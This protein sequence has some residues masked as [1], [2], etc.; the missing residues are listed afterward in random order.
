VNT[1]EVSAKTDIFKIPE[2]LL[3]GTLNNRN[4]F[5]TLSF[6][7]L[8]LLFFWLAA[9]GNAI[10][11][12]SAEDSSFYREAISNV[13][14]IY[15]HSLGEQLGIYNGPRYLQHPTLNQGHAYFNSSS[16]EYG[17]VVYDGILYDSVRLLYDEVKDELVTEDFS[18]TNFVQLIK[19]RTSAFTIREHRFVRIDEGTAHASGISSGFY[20]VL[21]DGKSRVL[22][23]ETKKITE[24]VMFGGAPGKVI[25]TK[26]NYFILHEGRYHRIKN[27]R[28]LLESFSQ[29]KQD[30]NAF[31]RKQDLS[32]KKN[33]DKFLIAVAA[34]YDQL[35]K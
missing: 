1:Q 4:C 2:R 22:K 14:K 12:S 31:I 30:L 18:Q 20:E 11:Q 35:T 3:R 21:Y 25:E 17:T 16:L 29:N 7:R 8:S 10:S 15:H 6:S 32:F 5:M 23:Q 33:A 34:F 24:Q 9:A 13:V 27:K 28:S 19:Q 26:L